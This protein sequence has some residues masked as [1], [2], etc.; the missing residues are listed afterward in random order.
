VE[1]VPLS[2]AVSEGVKLINALKLNQH[3]DYLRMAQALI[4]RKFDE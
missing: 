1:R 2:S 4:R 3:V